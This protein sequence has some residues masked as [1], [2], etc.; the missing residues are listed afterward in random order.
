MGFCATSGS[1]TPAP[2]VV[3][4][5]RAGLGELRNGAAATDNRVMELIGRDRELVALTKALTG[6]RAIVVVG[7]AGMGKTTLVRRALVE[8][9]VRWLE[10]GALG[11]LAWMPYFPVA[12][13]LGAP[14][15]VGDAAYVAA[16]VERSLSGGVLF[17]DDVQWADADTLALLPLLTPRVRLVAAVRHGGPA[18]DGALDQLS[19]L[20]FAQLPVEPLA[21][22]DTAALVRTIRSELSQTAVGLLVERSGGNPLLAE[23]LAA[24]GEV[25]ASTRLALGARLDGLGA[26]P[27][28]VLGLLALAGRPLD[29]KMLGADADGLVAGGLV[30][31]L[32][33]AVEIRHAL[34]AEAV[35]DELGVGER[36]RLHSELARTLSDAGEAARHH[37]A[38]GENEAAVE[39]ALAAAEAAERPGEVAAHLAVA[40]ANSRGESAD[41]LRLRAARA[42]DAAGDHAGV[43]RTLASVE[44]GASH[45]GAEIA[46]L[47]SRA[48]EATAQ[49]DEARRVCDEGH[50]LASPGTSLAVALAVQSARLVEDARDEFLERARSAL[51]VAAEAGFGEAASRSAFGRALLLGGRPAWTTQLERAVEAARREDDPRVEAEAAGTLVFGLLLDGRPAR[52]RPIAEAAAARMADL[53][54]S[55][56]ETRFRRWSA[57]LSWHLGEPRRAVD[58]TAALLDGVLSPLERHLAGFYHC[59]ALVDLGRHDQAA[60]ALDDVFRSPAPV[61]ASLGDALWAR[62]DAALSSGRPRD[63]VAAASEHLERFPTA[64]A[65]PFVEVTLAWAE[66]EHAGTP[67]RRATASPHRL[68]AGAP[69]EL[70]G[71]RSLAA[72]DHLAAA[73][74]FA[75]AA[76]RWRLRHVRGYLR[77]CWATG[78]ALRLAGDA[79]AARRRLES[80]E[81][82]ALSQGYVALGARIRRSLRLAG[83]RRSVARTRAAHGLTAR[84]REILDLVASGL[85]NAEIAARLGLGGPAVERAVESAS[86]KLGARS[87]VQAAVLAR[88]A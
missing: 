8:V 34:L 52:A 27:R 4:L 70:E 36:R 68:L 32:G 78:E 84:E 76:R 23:E 9:G 60:T 48:L 57:G 30:R 88:T 14:V 61:E 53:H 58:A 2:G 25:S 35:V 50:A 5:G 10:G 43:L 72:G 24:H 54:L 62:A 86:R 39:R 38:A 69:F 7:E 21:P 33:S 67:L 20:G 74:R 64:L 82:L 16:H 37:G 6:G 22:A 31:R 26:G 75:A 44:S 51:G 1:G 80:A 42:L 29:E 56:W 65:V 77:C 73:A 71:I 55:A 40:A 79:P 19:A 13:A 47:R 28:R 63:A 87:R 81:R 59:Q 45:A 3:P 18:A 66:L 83:R 17:L 85:S 41:A 46:L 15:P 11:T 12:R 49:L